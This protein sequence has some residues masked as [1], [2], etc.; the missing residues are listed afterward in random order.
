MALRLKCLLIR[1]IW[2][3]KFHNATPPTVFIRSGPNFMINTAVIGEYKVKDILAIGQK[4]KK[5]CGTLK[6]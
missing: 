2:G 4:I 6:F 1:T 3:W 5:K